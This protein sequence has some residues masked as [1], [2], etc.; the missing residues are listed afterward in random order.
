[1]N[2]FFSAQITIPFCHFLEV[3]PKI[4]RIRLRLH[5][6]GSQQG[7][8]VNQRVLEINLMSQSRY[9]WPF[10]ES[11]PLMPCT[12]GVYFSLSFKYSPKLFSSSSILAHSS[13]SQ[14]SLL[15]PHKPPPHPPG[16]WHAVASQAPELDVAAETEVDFGAWGV[17]L[18]G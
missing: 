12:T 16:F 17:I 1:M 9:H 7:I 14:F 4:Q 13:Y 18:G 15:P 3:T 2:K 5:H 6:W 8:S 10:K 11:S